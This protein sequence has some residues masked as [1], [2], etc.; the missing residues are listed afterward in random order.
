[1]PCSRHCQSPPRR[2]A[3]R[4]NGICGLFRSPAPPRPRRSA[5]P[6]PRPVLQGLGLRHTAAA[7]RG[8]GV[9]EVA[10]VVAAAVAFL[11]EVG[12]G[13][14]SRCTFAQ[15]WIIHIDFSTKF[16]TWVFTAAVGAEHGRQQIEAA[17]SLSSQ[18][19]GR[20]RSFGHWQVIDCR[21]FFVAPNFAHGSFPHREASVSSMDSVSGEPRMPATCFTKASSTK[22]K[23][24]AIVGHKSKR[25]LRKLRRNL[26]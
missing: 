12:D 8:L 4:R 7:F 23:S 20:G 3:R 16:F 2:I 9:A 11:A 24:T 6:R 22:T 19:L 13:P 25:V 26:R 1:M 15:I 10:A 18:F 5:R 17:P 14:I 21:R